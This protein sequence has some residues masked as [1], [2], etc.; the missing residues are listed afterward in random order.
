MDVSNTAL[1][2]CMTHGYWQYCTVL[3][4]DTWLLGILH[5]TC[6]WHMDAS[7]TALTC[8]WHMDTRITALHI[9]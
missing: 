8:V 4:Y 7:N 9:D 2:V 1:Y 3:V 6:V 5:C